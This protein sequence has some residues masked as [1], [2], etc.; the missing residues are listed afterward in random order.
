VVGFSQAILIGLV[1]AYAA[2][3]GGSAEA[4]K[5]VEA[6]AAV[7]YIMVLPF[8]LSVGAWFAVLSW[9]RFLR[10]PTLLN[11]AETAWNSY[12][13]LKNTYDAMEHAPKAVAT[14]VE[15]W[16]GLWTTD[17]GDAQFGWWAFLAV[18]S[19]VAI[20][21][22]GGALITIRI[23]NNYKGTLPAPEGR[24]LLEAIRS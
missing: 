6:A 16:A 11:G 18:A 23:M 3:N 1:V 21:F 20:A 4:M 12:A 8:V 24:E 5:T 19:I 10:E 7:W 17:A 13:A 22:G 2:W 9:K 15:W 14:I